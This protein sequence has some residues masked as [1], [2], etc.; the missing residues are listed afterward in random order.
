[1]AKL[2]IGIFDLTDCEGC[3]L[4]F[5]ALR[6]KLFTLS[7]FAEITNWRLA[8]EDNCNGPFDIA[9]VEGSPLNKKDIKL[10][11]SIRK[12]S[13]VVVA[14]GDCASIAGIP[15]IITESE[16][17]KL[18]KKIY[19]PKYEMEVTKVAPLS[20]YID[21]DYHLRGCPVLVPELEEFITNVIWGKKITY[22][23]Y[24][25]CLECKA[26]DNHCVM[27]DGEPCLGTVTKG[28][29][30]ALCPTNG[31]RCYG[32]FGSVKG[33][34][35]DALEKRLT[36]MVGKTEAINQLEIFIKN[37]SWRENERTT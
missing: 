33:A 28:G 29:C 1:M 32:C 27:L 24:P 9:F 34:N 30:K 8:I 23:G 10:V 13:R 17:K 14:L 6:E 25:V 11:E 2:K 3:E 37:A 5:I 20:Y 31:H 35:I 7:E 18:A 36:E 4:Q 15:G 22:K 21:V 19:G 26:N 12:V 16:R